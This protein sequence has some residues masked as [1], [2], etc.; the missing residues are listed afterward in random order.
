MNKFTG[1][2]IRQSSSP[3]SKLNRIALVKTEVIDYDLLGYKLIYIADMLRIRIFYLV[4]LLFLWMPA[5]KSQLIIN[6]LMA[7]NATTLMDEDYYN[8]PDW[9][10]IYNTG[11]HN[12]V[13]SEYYL[14]DD[15]NN[16]LK[17]KLPFVYIN[18][19]QYNVIYCDKEAS[20][21]HSNFGLDADG[22]TIYLSDNTGNIIDEIDYGQQYMDVSY[23]RDP[24]KI[25]TWGYCTTP[26]P[27]AINS[28][29]LSDNRSHKAE[30]SIPASRVSSSTNLDLSGDGIRY[31]L[32]GKEPNTNSL[33]YT[34]PI[35]F[36]RTIIVKTKVFQ[37]YYIPSAIYANTYFYSE[38]DFTLPVIS[39][40]YNSEYFTDN[41]I[42]I[43]VRGTN[44]IAGNCTD[45]A[46]WNRDWERTAYFEFFDEN[47]I[48]Q[49]SQTVGV[50]VSGGC[51]RSFAEQKSISLYARNKYGNTKFN[52]SFFK[53]KPD[54]VSFNSILLRNSGN[55]VNITEL[56]DAFL[57]ALAN[58]SLDLDCQ[59]YQPAIIY[60]NG[61]YFG[62]MNIREKT[63]EEY[64]KSNYALPVDSTDFLEGAVN[65]G[66][67]NNY[68]AI[69][70]TTDD[71]SDLISFVSSNSLAD[72]ENYY[73][74]ISQMDLQEYLNYMA[75]E[76]YIANTD[77]P[78]NNLKF[79]KRKTNGKWRW[80]VYDTD[81][82][83]GATSYDHKT[84]DFATEINGPSWPNPPW[85]TL[86]FRKLLENESFKND[87][88]RTILTLRNT[89][90]Q[91]EW[92]NYVMD[93]LSSRI[94]Y[95]MPYHKAR[96][97]GDMS[98]WNSSVNDLK[99]FAQ[100]RYNFIPDYIASYFGITEEQVIIAVDNP[101]RSKGDVAINQSVIKYYP[102]NMN[103]YQDIDLSIKAIPAKGYSFKQWNYSEQTLSY[104]LINQGSD[105][106]YLDEATDYPVDWKNI[107]FDDSAW[108]NGFAQLGYGD[109]DENTVISYGSDPNNKIPTALFRK[110]FTIEDTAGIT[111][112]QLGLNADDGAVVYLNGQEICRNNMPD[113]TPSFNMYTSNA[114]AN[115]NTFVY[116]DIAKS[117][118]NPGDNIIAC[119]VHQANRTSSDISFDLSVSYNYKK[120]SEAGVFSYNP[121]II[122]DTSYN[123]SVEPEFQPI[124][125]TNGIYLNEI[126]STTSL[127]RDE[128]NEKSG[129]VEIH[130]S[131][132]EDQVLYSFFVSDKPD[133][134][135]RYAIPDSSVIPA[136]GFITFYLD[137]EARQG[138]MHAPFK[139]N[140][141]G[142]SLYLS[143][144]IGNTLI[145]MDSVN[146]S[147]LVEDRSYGR[148][149]DGTGKWQ[150]M[151]NLTPGLANDP[152]VIV[153]QQEYEILTDNLIIY[154]NP[155]NGQIN[156]SVT[157]FDKYLYS[158]SVDVVDLSGKIVHPRVMIKSNVQS[159]NLENLNNGLYIVRI[160]TDR[161]ILKTYKVI[162][163]A[164]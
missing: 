88:I 124:D 26:T 89:I 52:Y 93:S 86:L 48:K 157:D 8:F 73:Y 20:V 150:Y 19:G 92:C 4:M 40:S 47:G 136:G 94:E 16:L 82:G 99:Q 28:T 53:Q 42:G 44:G 151:V 9:V 74:V 103:T 158:L 147:F 11:T 139:A 59:A 120:Y 98:G 31:T 22:E 51:S 5:S 142:E 141:D 39:L 105:W 156:I 60:Y 115:E 80:L 49:I 118:F 128:Y 159:L 161:L 100:A 2:Q 116:F 72:E 13:L 96:F 12:L 30:Y 90:F 27:G 57:Q 36:N 79:W 76:I 62:I 37:D 152:E 35:I 144:K 119:E 134:L 34:S 65:S 1:N 108:K 38:H 43:Y 123:L 84:M 50:K 10:E 160:F 113:G 153:G 18:A 145:T 75:Y 106:N 97:G 130:N 64:L 77:W 81:F 45:A 154:P 7:T 87:F 140:S 129:F 71:F 126:A 122:S 102:F 67:S 3:T 107:G 21:W 111:N 68:G 101:D 133:N 131:T 6:E 95:E 61:S 17:W 121:Y 127:F 69:C 63:N 41:T 155:S 55:D 46:N 58:E 33:L 56:R 164:N 163:N 143:Q 146:F 135:M 23:G 125:E 138:K 109:G 14:S 54:M 148:Y 104:N 132:G 32:D 137:A 24:S 149:P 85:A 162:I 110:K 114:I 112:V 91:P 117:L 66:N 25:Y 83:F 78:G 70:G 15:K 29:L